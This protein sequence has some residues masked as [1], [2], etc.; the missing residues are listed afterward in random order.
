[1]GYMV[2]VGAHTHAEARQL[3]HDTLQA[4]LGTLDAITYDETAHIIDLLRDG[5][6]SG[7]CHLT[8]RAGGPPSHAAQLFGWAMNNSGEFSELRPQGRH[9]G[10]WSRDTAYLIPGAFIADLCN[11]Q[12][13][14]GTVPAFTQRQV[15]R[16]LHERG[17]GKRITV[18]GKQQD[19]WPI[20]ID[21]LLP[22]ASDDP[23]ET[24]ASLLLREHFG[25]TAPRCGATEGLALM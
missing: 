6:L 23:D 19:V 1:M 10:Y 3:T 15:A 2:R 8:T 17:Y 9:I 21:A 13:Q 14:L 24:R 22:E 18:D 11:A 5:L 25:A 20:R 12:R 16:L 4:L 7:R